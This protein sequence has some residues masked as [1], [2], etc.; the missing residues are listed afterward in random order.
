MPCG[1]LLDIHRWQCRLELSG[2]LRP[3]ESL[4]VAGALGAL[5]RLLALRCLLHNAVRVGIRPS[6]EAEAVASPLVCLPVHLVQGG[7]KTA[8]SEQD[9]QGTD[10]EKVLHPSSVTNHA[11]NV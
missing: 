10:S 7:D 9:D 5:V 6:P 1:N 8:S 11:G 4:A 2:S 3:L